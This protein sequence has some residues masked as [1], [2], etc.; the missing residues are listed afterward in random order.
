MVYQ[1]SAGN[2]T[3]ILAFSVTNLSNTNYVRLDHN[4]QL[5]SLK[6]RL[7]AKSP[8]HPMVLQATA[9]RQGS[10]QHNPEESCH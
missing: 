2:R 10:N 5:F 6:R 3:N 7:K 1:C 9:C 8:G 4:I